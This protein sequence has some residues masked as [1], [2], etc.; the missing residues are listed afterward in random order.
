MALQ[1][2]RD[3][4]EAGAKVELLRPP[5]RWGKWAA[6]CTP[7]H[8]LREPLRR[9]A[10]ASLS[11]SRGILRHRVRA[12]CGWGRGVAR[13]IANCGGR[14]VTY[15]SSGEVFGA[16]LGKPL[17]RACALTGRLG[18]RGGSMD[19]VLRGYRHTS[20]DPARP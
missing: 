8:H 9:A 10:A 7:D 14:T 6:A 5:I 19:G 11:V 3:L 1:W 17:I 15:H 4:T 20:C 12:G 2:D 13:C 16:G 18:E